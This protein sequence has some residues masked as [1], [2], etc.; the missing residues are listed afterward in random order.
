M[1]VSQ[2]INQCLGEIKGMDITNKCN[3]KHLETEEY[4]NRCP[5]CFQKSL[6]LELK[7]LNASEE[8]ELLHKHDLFYCRSCKK[9]LTGETYIRQ[10]NFNKENGIKI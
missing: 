1:K 10:I 8:C 9:F 3:A 4:P 5:I 2:T 6:R 7:A